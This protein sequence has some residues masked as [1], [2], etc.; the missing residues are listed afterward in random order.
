MAEVALMAIQFSD[1]ASSAGN[2]TNANAK[3][4]TNVS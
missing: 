2:A 1:N 4:V 3:F